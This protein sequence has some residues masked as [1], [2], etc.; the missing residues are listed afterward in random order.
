VLP[1]QEYQVT[2]TCTENPDSRNE[3]D[4]IVIC[5]GER[6]STFIISSKTDAATDLSA[7]GWGLIMAGALY[8]VIWLVVICLS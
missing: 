6:E 2:G 7:F 8:F 1:G 4:R 5:M 3:D